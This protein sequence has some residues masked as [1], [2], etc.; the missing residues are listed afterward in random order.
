MNLQIDAIHLSK[1][2]SCDECGARKLCIMDVL[3]TLQKEKLTSYT[4]KIHTFSKGEILFQAGDALQN[5]YLLKSG[6]A[7]SFLIAENGDEQ[8]TGFHFPG[9]ILGLES[10]ANNQYHSSTLFLENANICRIDKNLFNTLGS[11]SSLFQ[12]EI[13]TRLTKETGHLS[14][15][16]FS[17]NH[18]TADQ[19]L[20]AFILEL[21]GRMELLGLSKT[22]FRLSMSRSDIANYLGLASETVSRS[23]KKFERDG[24]IKVKN[25]NLS[26]MDFQ[27]LIYRTHGCSNC[28]QHLSAMPLVAI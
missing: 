27:G 28:T 19:N 11:E 12:H 18:L 9:E 1:T 5:L 23:F 22:S 26:I 17:T 20:A 16:L 14:K 24:L 15:L 7:K 6:S 4:R 2:I 10:I 13:F 21:S 8:I 3:N 25:K